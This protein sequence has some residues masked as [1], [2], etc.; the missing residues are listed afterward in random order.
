[1]KGGVKHGSQMSQ[2]GLIKNAFIACEGQKISTIGPMS[3]LK[4]LRA[5]RT[6]DAQGAVVMPGLIDCHTHLVF[7][8]NRAHEFKLKLQGKSYLEILAS[9]GG[10]L[11][12]VKATRKA[13][14]RTLKENAQKHL[15]DMLRL[16][17]T[18]I[19]AKSGYGLDLQTEIKTLKI[20]QALQKTTPIKIIPTFLAAHT[21]P[22]EYQNR[23]DDY[24]ELLKEKALPKIKKLAHFVDIFCEKKAFNL[25]QSQQY[26]Q[27]ALA[28]GFKIKIH[29]EQITR[30]GACLMAA[31]LGATS[32]DH[33]DQLNKTD[34]KRLAQIPAKSQ[35]IIVLL[36][37][38]PLFLR[39]KHFAN[40]RLMIDQGLAIAVST[41]FNPGSSPSKN[42]YLAMTLACLKMGLTIEEALTATTIN[43]AAALD[44]HHD[45][46][47]L[48]E[49]KTADIIIT[50]ARDYQ[51]IPYWLGENMAQS[52][53]AGGKIIS[54]SSQQPK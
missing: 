19:E 1:M 21:I 51:E 43:A 25:K 50:K 13:S 38:V 39:E 45:R 8:A 4:N 46:G 23:A 29:G 26:L 49:G 12:T 20:L 17:V 22:P 36:P 48:E 37:L 53:I 41:D 6:I 44:L 11:S 31:R 15:D 28:Q 18:T 3:K 33:A 54:P 24:L 16:G 52:V 35:P 30:L 32:V 5:T 2:L 10:I 14:T 47:S 7:A 27:A 40:G 42:L 34:I 9:G